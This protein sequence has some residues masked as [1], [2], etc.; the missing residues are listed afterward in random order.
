MDGL[1][2][3]VDGRIQPCSIARGCA[4]RMRACSGRMDRRGRIVSLGNMCHNAAASDLI[5]CEEPRGKCQYQ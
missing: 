1:V 3:D 5:V 2:P 4:P